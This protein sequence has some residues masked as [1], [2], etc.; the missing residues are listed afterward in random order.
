[1]IMLSFVALLVQ[2]SIM[3]VVAL[4]VTLYQTWHT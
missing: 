2:S 4:T 1:M 3:V